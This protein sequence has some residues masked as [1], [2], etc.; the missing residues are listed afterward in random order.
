L[1][2]AR[3]PTI[4]SGASYPSPSC[5]HAPCLAHACANVLFAHVCHTCCVCIDLSSLTFTYSPLGGRAR[6][7]KLVHVCALCDI[8]RGSARALLS[9]WVHAYFFSAICN[10][11]WV[12]ISFG[13]ICLYVYPCSC[14]YTLTIPPPHTLPYYTQ[15]K[16]PSCPLS[17]IQDH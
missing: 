5:Q 17:P 16:H 4:T 13:H 2:L 6:A 15:T 1:L 14:G 3:L 8:Q 12:L 9:M 10:E 7:S 11:H